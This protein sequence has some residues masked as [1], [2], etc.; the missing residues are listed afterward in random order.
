MSIAAERPDPGEAMASTS[1]SSQRMNQTPAGTWLASTARAARGCLQGL[2]AGMDAGL[3]AASTACHMLLAAQLM[4]F[5]SMPACLPSFQEMRHRRH[6]ETP[7]DRR[8]R[9]LR[10]KHRLR[11]LS[12]TQ[13][14]W[15]NDRFAG[16][17]DDSLPAAAYTVVPTQ[18]TRCSSV[19]RTQ[20]L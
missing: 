19:D 2:S 13:P 1:A 9:E 11:K 16:G 6:L 8:K 18:C 3:A 4:S 17:P 5:F 7:R 15:L 14:D 20:P 12:M 10:D